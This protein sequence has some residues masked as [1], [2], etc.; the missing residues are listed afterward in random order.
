MTAVQRKGFPLAGIPLISL[1]EVTVT[2][3][4]G[5]R[6][7]KFPVKLPL[8]V[9]SAAWKLNGSPV[10]GGDKSLI[11]P[12]PS[13]CLLSNVTAGKLVK[14][15]PGMTNDGIEN[16]TKPDAG[17]LIKPDTG[18]LIKPEIGIL[19]PVTTIGNHSEFRDQYAHARE[20]EFC[21]SI[22]KG[23]ISNATLSAIGDGNQPFGSM[24]VCFLRCL[25]FIS[26]LAAV[27]RNPAVLSP[28]C[29]S[30]S[31]PSITSLGILT[32]VIC[33]FAFLA[34][35]GITDTPCFRCIS[36]YAKKMA[37]KA[38]RCISVWVKFKSAGDIHLGT[39]KP[40]SAPTLA[41]PLTKPLIEVTVMAVNQHTPNHPEFVWRFLALPRADMQ[42]KPCRISVQAES[43]RE[44]RR[45]L[46]PHYILPLA[47]RLPVQEVAH[48]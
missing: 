8:L 5:L 22:K 34:P 47:A 6:T 19:I 42:A 32:V 45:V 44:A 1:R 9:T 13:L 16:L 24:P 14:V 25:R 2:P 30:D 39:S 12:T 48:A 33:D 18:N 37:A 15:S 3:R 43:E 23:S 11:H 41:G 4:Y 20:I 31:M 10:T 26:P 46:A 38:L 27:T 7:G 40:G 36:V 21:E 17:N 28:S 35:V 29:F